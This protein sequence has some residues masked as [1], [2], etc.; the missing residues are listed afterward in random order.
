[1]SLRNGQSVDIFSPKTASGTYPP[2]VV[3]Q[4]AILVPEFAAL[5]VSLAFMDIENCHTKFYD[6]IEIYQGFRKGLKLRTRTCT[7]SIKNFN[8]TG[9]V[10]IRFHSDGVDQRKGFHII[11]HRIEGGN[12]SFHFTPL[13]N[14]MLFM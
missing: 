6:Y 8:F 9:D 1:M 14:L 5:N 4:W 12:L 11:V 10:T 3:C 7:N 2:N 13:F